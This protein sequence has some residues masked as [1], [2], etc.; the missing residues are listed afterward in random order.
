MQQA[1]FSTEKNQKVSQTVLN[2]KK[3]NRKGKERQPMAG[4]KTELDMHT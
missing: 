4:V 3:K 1:I 2:I